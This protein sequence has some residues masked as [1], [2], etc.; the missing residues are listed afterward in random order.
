MIFLKKLQS[1][2]EKFNTN[3]QGS[4]TL[5]LALT[6]V[7]ILAF[8]FSMVEAARV[9]GLQELAQRKLK[10]ET[11]SLF[12][13]YNQELWEHYDLLFL[14]MSYGSGEPDVRL[15]EG[16]MMENDYAEGEE[17]HFYQMALKDVEVEAYALATDASGAEFVRQACE[18][19]KTRLAQ[20][21]VEEL[22]NRIGIWQGVEKQSEDLEQKWEEALEAEKTAESY[23]ESNADEIKNSQTE[24]EQ[25]ELGIMAKTY[26]EMLTENPI[27]YV[28]NLKESPV[29]AL[30]MEEPSELSGKG[31]D[32]A[33]SL[34]NRTL[35]CGNLATEQM[36]S[37]DKMWFIQYLNQYFYCK[38]NVPTSEH[39]LDYELEYCIAG[40][41]TDAQNL[42]T[43]VKKLLLFRESANFITIMK[44]SQK[45]SL[46]LEIATALVGFTGIVPLIETVKIG[47]LLAWCYVESIMDLRSLLA[48][49]KVSL[50]KDGS[51]WK[52][53]LSHLSK[54]IAQNTDEAEEKGLSYQEYL[55]ILLYLTEQEQLT[56]RAMDVVERNIR[57]FSG[58][59]AISM[60]AMVSAVQINATYSAN[61]LFLNVVPME[62]KINGSYYFRKT[63]KFSY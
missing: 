17:S 55:Q 59:E 50:I 57:L 52:S 7:L 38:A 19:A 9:N 35:S 5:F 44:D 45:K 24:D 37:V 54:E 28:T 53:D 30:V 29:L 31:I 36:S 4:I 25:A 16:R 6:M 47:I 21:G 48:G 3:S 23:E 32:I 51:E 33:T 43:V 40:K 56:Y 8:L 20:D 61:P 10:L 27:D 18:A 14:D 15:L 63:Q 41:S 62:S 49:G 2:Q 13:A 39:A 26:G 34:D 60:D 11:E 58:N 22:K 42:E 1:R 46:A 12:G